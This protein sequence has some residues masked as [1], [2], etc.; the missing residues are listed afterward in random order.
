MRYNLPR[1][2]LRQTDRARARHLLTPNSVLF[3]A[4]VGT[5]M[6]HPHRAL[7]GA[8]AG[9]GATCEGLSQ[10]LPVS[11]ADEH[12]CTTQ[13]PCRNG[14]QCVYDGGGEYHCVCPPGF[15]GRDCERKAG[16]CE[17]AG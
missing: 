16:P 3:S 5:S 10:T 8:W 2:T 17:Q 4:Q 15:H 6:S 1:G 7:G 12:I 13:S 9:L 14:G 11:S